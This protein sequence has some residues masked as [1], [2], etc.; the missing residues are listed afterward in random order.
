MQQPQPE[1][2]PLQLPRS[3]GYIV[4]LKKQVSR[5]DEERVNASARSIATARGAV[6]LNACCTHRFN[7]FAARGEL[8]PE[9]R[10]DL[11]RSGDV[12]T[13]EPDYEVRAFG[14]TVSSRTEADA[15]WGAVRIGLFE[16]G[17]S[18]VPGCSSCDTPRNFDDVDV[19]VLDTGVQSD[20][21][22]LNVVSSAS[23][24]T[25]SEPEADDMNGHGTQCAGI[26]GA[27][28][29]GW[30]ADQAI[31]V[32]GVAPGARI[33]GLKVLDKDGS[34]FLSDIILGV[35]EVVRFKELH[36][37]R[38]VV[39]NM[40][41]GGYV[42]TT[43]YTALDR[44]VEAAIKEY[45]ITAFIAAGNSSSDASLFCPAHVKEAVT[46]GCYD[47]E[48]RFSGFSNFGAAV[49]I[50]AP[51]NDIAST[52]IGSGVTSASGTSFACP[53]VCGAGV[54]VLSGKKTVQK[55]H[56]VH[57]ALLDAATPTPSSIPLHNIPHGTA[58]LSL[59]LT[60]LR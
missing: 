39:M 55:P 38:T 46:V 36:P 17:R 34:G 30:T 59:H 2:Q 6:P 43:Q 57:A 20:H 45:G 24:L 10:E 54:L 8:S 23:M 1:Q 40:S 41:L 7:G 37:E 53:F 4:T 12:E 35:E 50:L 31:D 29:R 48:G 21:P 27:L 33:H 44:E 11:E 42:G 51:G 5:E 32:V 25:N 22:Y 56:Q 3:R 47:R 52:T 14:M 28:D 60:G 58:S 9:C 49:D 16:G 26:I 13:I 19:F 18:L 15:P